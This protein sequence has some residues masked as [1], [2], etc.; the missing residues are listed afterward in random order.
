V[1]GPPGLNGGRNVVKNATKPNQF[2]SPKCSK[3]VKEMI[4]NVAAPC[5]ILYGSCK[6]LTIAPS[7]VAEKCWK[8]H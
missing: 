3:I 6:I 2:W 5:K 8:K 7:A 4:K 1:A